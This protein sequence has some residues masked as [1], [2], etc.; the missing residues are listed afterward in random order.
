MLAHQNDL[1]YFEEQKQKRERAKEENKLFLKIQ[2]E[3]AK[4]RKEHEEKYLK[5]KTRTHFGPE[6]DEFINDFTKKREQQNK[7]FM[8]NTLRGQIHENVNRKNTRKEIDRR[9]DLLMLAK[10]GE[11]MIGENEESAIKDQGRKEVFK[12]VWL[13]QIDV[14]N[15]E[16]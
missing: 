3:E 11:V 15:Q 4:L 6:N 12:R 8:E 1:R 2:M 7:A 16:K 13:E 5:E 10:A 9:E 14:K